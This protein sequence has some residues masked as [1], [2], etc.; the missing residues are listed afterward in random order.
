[1]KKNLFF[2]LLSFFVIVIGCTKENDESSGFVTVGKTSEYLLTVEKAKELLYDFIS[3]D[4]TIRSGQPLETTVT[5]YKVT[6]YKIS[7]ARMKSEAVE[8]ESVPV[9]ELITQ[10]KG[11]T[12][13]SIVI[14]D[15][16]IAKVLISVEQ[17]S[18]ADTLKIVPLREYFRAIPDMISNDLDSFYSKESQPGERPAVTTRDFSV[19]THYAFVPTLWHQWEPYNNACPPCYLGGN[20]PAGCVPIALAQIMAYHRKPA[21]LNW[22]A[23]LSSPKITSNSSPTVIN[24]VATFI[25]EIGEKTHT[26]YECY[27]TTTSSTYLI[28]ALSYF[29]YTSGGYIYYTLFDVITSLS[30]SRPVFMAGFNSNTSPT[31]HA[32]VCDGYKKHDYGGGDAYEY[33]NMNWGWEDASSNGFFIVNNPPSYNGFYYNLRIIPNIK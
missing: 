15:S 20:C 30:N 8:I 27:F 31:G 9:Y 25:A 4:V 26:V 22:T 19:T 6:N 5:N 32:W 11:K 33:L 29:G 16:R 3:S 14:A 13:Y 7:S 10:S 21:S 24:Q 17:G 2:V 1:M 18:A 23:I 28:T 12:G